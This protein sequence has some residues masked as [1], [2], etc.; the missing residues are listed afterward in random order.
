MVAKKQDRYGVAKNKKGSTTRRTGSRV[1]KGKSAGDTMYVYNRTTG[2]YTKK[3]KAQVKK[4]DVGTEKSGA[5][6]KL[7]TERTFN[8]A[9]KIKAGQKSLTPKAVR[10]PNKEKK[11]KNTRKKIRS[12][13]TRASGSPA[14]KAKS[15]KSL[16]Y[17]DRDRVRRWKERK[18]S[19]LR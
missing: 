18:K 7:I 6:Y 10:A 15:S 2:S 14:G 12:G 9:K 8:S 19:T 1:M 16:S 4:L 3:S 17:A 13:T 5:K 11:A